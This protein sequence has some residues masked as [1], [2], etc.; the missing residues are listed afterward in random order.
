MLRMRF[1]SLSIAGFWLL[2]SGCGT[3]EQYLQKGKKAAAAGKQAEAVLDFRKAIQKNPQ[4]VDAFRELADS[5]MRLGDLAGAMASYERALQLKPGDDELRTEVADAALTLYLADPQRPRT[6]YDQ[7]TKLSQELLAKDPKSF[8]GLRFKASLLYTDNRL[9]EAIEVYRQADTVKPW[10]P[11]VVQP[12]AEALRRNGQIAEAESLATGL[13]AQHKDNLSTYDW[14]YQLYEDTQRPAKAE[15]ILVEKV[16]NN[17]ASSVAILQLASYYQKTNKPTE[18]AAA[19][20]QLIQRPK[21]FPNR[22]LL[23]GGFYAATRNWDDAAKWFETGLKEDS[24]NSG[25]YRRQMIGVYLG[26]QKRKE[27]LDLFDQLIQENPNDWALRTQRAQV[28]LAGTDKEE[29]KKAAGELELLVKAQPRDPR[30][31][32][33]LGQAYLKKGDKDLA[34]QMFA[35]AAAQQRSFLE[36]RIALAGLDRQTQDYK[37]TLRLADEILAVDPN[38]FEG[39][40]LHASASR[41]LGN[42][43]IAQNELEA[44]ARQEPHSPDVQLEL[45][46]TT[47]ARKQYAAA[48]RMFTTLYQSSRSDVRALAGLAAVYLAEGRGDEAVQYVTQEVNRLPNSLE[49]R[50]LLAATALNTGKSDIALDQYRKLIQMAPDNPKYYVSMADLFREKSD[51]GSEVT[52]LETASKLEP[53]NAVVAGRLALAEDLSGNKQAAAAEYKQSLDMAP[54]D[55]ALLNNRAYFLAEDGGDLDQALAY[56]Q[57][58]LR[59]VPG[60]PALLDTLAWVYTKRKMNDSAIQILNKLVHDN[61][62]VS[63]FHYHL[64][65]A[66]AQKGEKAKARTE[67]A[68]AL[69]K[70]PSPDEESKIKDLI[71]KLQ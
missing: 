11:E 24:K 47:L 42:L 62:D 15:A 69:S 53:A 43:D 8:D 39:K 7:V 68:T 13:I 12:M 1:C 27:A 48:E 66:L 14:L 65:T 52:A 10:R 37:D 50:E 45:G 16:A 2:L 29:V 41:G 6:R 3:P 18:T 35:Q 26:Q 57:E 4:Y 49:M 25:K 58:A 5:Q 36:P 22:F 64:G 9:P 33:L 34:G 20:N 31:K 63:S 28:W 51:Y 21:D 32:F 60:N 30:L 71:G 38:N 44:L 23:V 46:L 59:K 67:L 54:S 56:S 61:P 70:K 19:L 40:L 55:P 17:P